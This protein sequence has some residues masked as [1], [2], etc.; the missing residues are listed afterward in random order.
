MHAFFACAL[1]FLFCVLIRDTWITFDP[2]WEKGVHL[3]I[4]A[5][6]IIYYHLHVCL[7]SLLSSNL[8]N[9]E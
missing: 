2:E 4:F 5:F 3:L 6:S 1:G 8:Q 7:L 9:R